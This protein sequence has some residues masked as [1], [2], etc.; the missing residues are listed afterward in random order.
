MAL[1]LFPAASTDNNHVVFEIQ[2]AMNRGLIRSSLPETDRGNWQW[3]VMNEG[4]PELGRPKTFVFCGILR[5]LRFAAMEQ[6]FLFEPRSDG[7]GRTADDDQTLG[8]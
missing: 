1:L 7:G 8:F 4:C 2:H 3:A 6:G 5:S